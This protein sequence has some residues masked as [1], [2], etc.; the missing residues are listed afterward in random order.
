MQHK[1]LGLLCFSL[2]GCEFCLSNEVEKRSSL[3]VS[4]DV[5]HI[6]HVVSA[7]EQSQ[8]A[9]PRSAEVALQ[10]FFGWQLRSAEKRASL[11]PSNLSLLEDPP[12]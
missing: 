2:F 12:L 7:G 10:D 3:A 8:R 4:S 5:S 11:S 9:V 6:L 1:M